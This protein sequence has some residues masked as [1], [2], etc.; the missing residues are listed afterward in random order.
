MMNK[1]ARLLASVP[2]F[3]L[4]AALGGCLAS[5]QGVERPAVAPATPPDLA[6]TGRA[7]PATYDP[8]V[9]FKNDFWGREWPDGFTVD[10]DITLAVR[11][12]PE[13]GAPKSVSCLLRRGA[14]YHPW[15]TKRVKADRLRFVT[16][17]RIRTY[18]LTRDY[19]SALPRWPKGEEVKVTLK[20]G[21]RWSA[22]GPGAEGFFLMRIGTEVYQGYQDIF[23]A[24]TEVAGE[25]AARPEDDDHEWLQLR[26][27][28]GMTGW[29]FYADVKDAPGFSRTKECGFGCAEDRKPARR[30]S[31]RSPSDANR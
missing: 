20:A 1:V 19:S 29:I 30:G 5:A 28:N 22:V 27:A 6:Q 17:S 11:T 21:D 14:T 31:S 10:K 9:W 25:P 15:N 8:A 4:A 13:I 23:D 2:T 18:Q 12:E 26:C 3:G 24:S 7:G 16:F